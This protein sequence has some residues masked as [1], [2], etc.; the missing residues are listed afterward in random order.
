MQVESAVDYVN[1]GSFVYKP[2]YVFFAQSYEYRLQGTILLTISFD[3]LS[4]DRVDAK[5]GYKKILEPLHTTFVIQVKECRSDDDLL[6]QIL[7]K[8]IELETH[9]AREFLRKRPT[10]S[11]PFHPHRVECMERYC[12]KSGRSVNDDINYGAYAPVPAKRRADEQA[13]HID[14][15]PDPRNGEVIAKIIATTTK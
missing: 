11:A 5:E 1:G 10:Y 4:T 9:E 13:A 12:E 14:I 15:V 7:T 8:I 3:A 2:G 6:Y